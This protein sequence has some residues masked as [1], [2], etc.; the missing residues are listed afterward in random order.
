MDFKKDAF[1]KKLDGSKIIHSQELDEKN[2]PNKS[3]KKIVDAISHDVL[4]PLKFF[5]AAKPS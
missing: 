4:N 2:D 3:N 5:N 1:V